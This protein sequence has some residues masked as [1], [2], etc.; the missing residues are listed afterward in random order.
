MARSILVI[1]QWNLFLFYESPA[2]NA[3]GRFLKD[4]INNSTQ[5]IDEDLLAFIKI[6]TACYTHTH[7]LSDYTTK[8]FFIN[9][10]NIDETLRASIVNYKFINQV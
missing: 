6:G 4:P 9:I 10:T 5:I 7:M 8:Q 1:C 3:G 2:R